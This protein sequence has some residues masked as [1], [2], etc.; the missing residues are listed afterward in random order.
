MSR[1]HRVFMQHASGSGCAADLDS[2]FVEPSTRLRAYVQKRQRVHRTRGCSEIITCYVDQHTHTRRHERS[3][4]GL[5]LE[6]LL[7]E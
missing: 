6:L 3:L 5:H 1:H 4:L 7:D 2:W